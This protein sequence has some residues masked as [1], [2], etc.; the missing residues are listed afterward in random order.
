[1]ATTTLAEAT[2]ELEGLEDP[3]AREVNVRHG[4]DHG[5]HLGALRTLEMVR[6][7]R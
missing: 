3:K 1:M 7:A 4:D 5:V 6:R 2:A